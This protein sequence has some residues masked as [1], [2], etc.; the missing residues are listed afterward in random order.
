MF[1]QGVRTPSKEKRFLH[2]AAGDGIKAL[3]GRE[4]GIPEQKQSRVTAEPGTS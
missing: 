2:I 4:I 1:P 3:T